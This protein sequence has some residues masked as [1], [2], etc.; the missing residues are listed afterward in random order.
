MTNT[1]RP[2]EYLN[3]LDRAYR[4]TPATA[5]YILERA[6]AKFRLTLTEVSADVR[7]RFGFDFH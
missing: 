7:A 5:A 2:A 3:E 4:A 6:A 1:A